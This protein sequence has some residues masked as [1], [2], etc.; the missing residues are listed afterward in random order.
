MNKYL[1]SK[2]KPC[3]RMASTH[4]SHQVRAFLRSDLAS[5]RRGQRSLMHI[6]RQSAGDTEGSPMS[7]LAQ[8]KQQAADAYLDAN[9]AET[10]PLS[11][12][13]TRDGRHY[14]NGEELVVRLTSN[15]SYLRKETV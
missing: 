12:V 2:I 1:P 8:V 4:P 15:F 11:L 14:V 3:P 6:S 13:S 5:I 10:T 9:T 7:T